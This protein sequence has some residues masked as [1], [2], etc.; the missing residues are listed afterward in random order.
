MFLPALL[1]EKLARQI[2]SQSTQALVDCNN[3]NLI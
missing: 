3:V 2:L 1:V